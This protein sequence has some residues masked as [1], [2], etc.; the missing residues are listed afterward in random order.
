[1]S[2]QRLFYSTFQSGE[3]LLLFLLSL[4]QSFQ[5]QSFHAF[6]LLN[7]GFLLLDNI[8]F[9]LLSLLV[10]VLNAFQNF[11]SSF[12]QLIQSVCFV[13]LYFYF[14]LN[15]SSYKLLL[16]HL[17]LLQYIWPLVF[18]F[19][20]VISCNIKPLLHSGFTV[21]LLS[22]PVLEE[23]YLLLP[24]H[25][26]SVLLHFHQSLISVLIVFLYF[27]NLL[28]SLPSIFYFL[29]YPRFFSLQHRYS[30]C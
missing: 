11:F 16:H 14:F 28:C 3:D 30:V 10:I 5:K 20:K 23:L 9:I 29:H 18:D 17:L 27:Q 24:N 12:M 13:L 4:L 25:Y 26:L 15:I 21:K 1:M 22:L 6:H 2:S 7:M 8:L 19:I